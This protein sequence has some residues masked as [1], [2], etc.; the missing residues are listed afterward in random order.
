MKITNYPDGSS[1]VTAEKEDYKDN[2]NFKINSYEDLW[3][4]NQYVDA[5]ISNFNKKPKIV[6]PCLLDAQ[7]DRRFHYNQS[8]GLKLICKFLNSIEAEF[9]IFHPHN[10]EVVE[11]L[12]DNVHIIDN[13]HYIGKVLKEL[14]AYD[15]K[16]NTTHRYIDDMILMSPDAGAFKPMVKL[17]DELNWSSEIYSAVK[18][19]NPE[20]HK[21]TQVISRDDFGGKD[22][23]IIDDLMVGGGTLKGLSTLLKNKNVGK[24]YAVVSHIT[25]QNLGE[26]PITNYFDQVFTTNSKFDSYYGGTFT[27]DDIPKGKY[28]YDEDPITNLTVI[29]LF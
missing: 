19:R 14:K 26:D 15:V 9:F 5:Y 25:V 4:L 28:R 10:P 8:S 1:Y 27:R 17:A 3:H 23:I 22:I 29:N 7:A 6:I 11:A 16:P 24:L 13:T 18:S 21:L 20:T 12:M 2:I